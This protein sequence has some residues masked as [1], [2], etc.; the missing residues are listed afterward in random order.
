MIRYAKR[1][2]VFEKTE[3]VWTVEPD[4]LVWSG[5]DGTFARA[6]WTDVL[7]V[8]LTYAPTRMKPWRHKLT[9]KTR[10]G[11]VWTID[12]A[13][14]QGVGEF[15][16]R[17]GSFTPFVLACVERIA[18][19]APAARARLG[20]DPLAYWAQLAFVALMFGL[21]AF[22]IIA[23][24]TPFGAVIWIKLGLIAVML[25]VMFSFAVRAWP[26]SADLDA[27]AFREA[28]P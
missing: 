11:A 24:P 9:L 16:D 4:A 26:R 15:E 18:A 7:S 17:S 12:N 8:R 27:E 1:E 22:V 14:F 13:H 21:L 23:L 19:L 20:S 25:P 3:R 6:P 28:L 2:N 10:D 5:M